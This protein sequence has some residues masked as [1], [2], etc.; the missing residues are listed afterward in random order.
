MHY[1][2]FYISHDSIVPAEAQEDAIRA[3][4]Y[5]PKLSQV[6]KDFDHVSPDTQ[7]IIV[8]NYGVMAP[9]LIKAA[10]IAERL[11]IHYVYLIVLK[12]EAGMSLDVLLTAAK[13]E[14]EIIGAQVRK[15]YKAKKDAGKQS[16]V[17]ALHPTVVEELFR[18]HDV[19]GL[20]ISEIA[21]KLDLTR[22]AVYSRL[23]RRDAKAN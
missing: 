23:K 1:Q 13:A 16:S 3:A 22:Q 11:Q 21:K 19:E 12:P 20:G 8:Y 9:S 15:R 4:G 14:R 2:M 18:L 5:D 10:E 6:L 7:E 17:R